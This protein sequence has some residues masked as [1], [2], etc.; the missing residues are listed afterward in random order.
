MPLRSTR[1]QINENEETPL[2]KPSF[3]MPCRSALLHAMAF[4]SVS[5]L[6]TTNPFLNPVMWC[7]K[8]SEAMRQRLQRGLLRQSRRVRKVNQPSLWYWGMICIGYQQADLIEKKQP[9]AC[10]P[11]PTRFW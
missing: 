3:T 1:Q 4:A 11:E 8:L 9:G 10:S 7:M 2:S 6:L 5:L